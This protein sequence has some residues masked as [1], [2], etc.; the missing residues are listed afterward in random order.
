VGINDRGECDFEYG[1]VII[2]IEIT[3]QAHLDDTNTIYNV[4]VLQM[5]CTDGVTRSM[6]LRTIL[7]DPKVPFPKLAAVVW[8]EVPEPE[9]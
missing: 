6:T 3:S 9:D 5:L 1:H 4:E 2:G 7:F 8:G